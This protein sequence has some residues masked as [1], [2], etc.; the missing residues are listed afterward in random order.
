MNAYQ[1][2]FAKALVLIISLVTFNQTVFAAPIELSLNDSVA[3][4]LKN[5]ETIKIANLNRGKTYWA[6]KQA[7]ASKGFT[8][9]Y[10]HTDERY[11]TPPS[12]L[13]PRYYWTSKFDNSF[14][15]SLPI[16]TGG[17]LENQIHQADLNVKV[18]DLNF[19]ATKQ[20]VKQ[21]VTNY[22]FSVLQSLK[23]L[24]VSQETVDN[25]ISHL[26]TVQLQYDT[27]TVAHSDVLSS[28]VS[29]AN[30]QNDL[31]KAQN[32]Y[33]LAVANLNNAIGLP[34]ESE[35]ILKEDLQIKKDVPSLDDCVK[36]ALVNR[37]ELAEYQAKIAIA[38]DDVNIAKGGYRPTVNFVAKE[39]WYD[40]ELPGSDNN[41][42]LVGLNVS[43]NIFDSGINK[44]K[45]KQS[46]I[47]MD[48]TLE[49][50]Q[51][52]RDSIVLEVRQYYLN[53]REAKNRIDTSNVAVDKAKDSLRI[54]E[55][56]YN[57]GVGTNLDVLDAVLAL[58]QVKTNYIQ[59]LYDYNTS[60]AQLDKAMGVPVNETLATASSSKK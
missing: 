33:E 11:N 59:A 52:E 29:L 30:A 40:N 25:Y 14:S 57:A 32:N 24:D 58:N 2:H 8:F 21:S 43:M 9:D 49:Q 28:E 36:Y 10:T 23:N 17:K 31:I 35:L 26:K 53:M 3:L 13:I 18:S 48:M 4:A 51:Q 20:Q 6:L 27:G 22:Y 44:S 46:Q 42:W 16:Y 60:K 50:A 41:N 54:A 15:L 37:P 47:S 38:Q 55:I 19:D 1:R 12:V 45:V 5:N 34:L 56:R 7:K 39:D